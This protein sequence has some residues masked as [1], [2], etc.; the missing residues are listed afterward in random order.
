MAHD[1][2]QTEGYAKLLHDA[3]RQGDVESVRKLVCE[4][5]RPNEPLDGRLPLVTA[6]LGKSHDVIKVLLE[7]GADVKLKGSSAISP[8]GIAIHQKDPIL[9]ET[10][11]GYCGSLAGYAGEPLISLALEAS[12]E[13][14]ALMLI[15]HG[16]DINKK[17]GASDCSPLM[18]ACHGKFPRAAQK[19]LE[20][21]ADIEERSL[22]G[23]TPLMVASCCS[24]LATAE[25]LID[26]RAKLNAKKPA[27]G[28]TALYY[29]VLY[30][31][32]DM[33]KL[34]VRKG[35]AVNQPLAGDF[36]ALSVAADNN[37]LEIASCLL[38]NGA[39]VSRPRHGDVDCPSYV[40]AY[41]DYRPTDALLTPLHL[42]AENGHAEMARLLLNH[43]ARIDTAS[44][45]GYTPLMLAAHNGHADT[46]ALLISRGADINAHAADGCRALSMAA[47]SYDRALRR[48]LKIGKPSTARPLTSRFG[49]KRDCE[50]PSRQY[51]RVIA[52][53][54]KAGSVLMPCI[55]TTGT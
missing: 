1:S 17:R 35:A 32:L 50:Q 13:V 30:Q 9:L 46:V 21:G 33:T 26:F 55:A 24:D 31:H 54:A 16:A 2:S 18:L 11:L 39:D 52:M 22:S 53:L 29:A 41:A 5:K 7:H 44:A 48:E 43:R 23:M 15:E 10:L 38:A 12:K 27:G 3:V 51:E 14:M 47:W 8:L 42:A 28:E 25:N 40:T 19:L 4:Y 6:V 49:F 37:S 36:T 20:M 45:C 34:L